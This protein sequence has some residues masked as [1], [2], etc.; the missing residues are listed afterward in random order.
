MIHTT[1]IHSAH[2]HGCGAA[3]SAWRSTDSTPC[4]LPAAPQRVARVSRRLQVIRPLPSPVTKQA[5]SARCHDS[6]ERARKCKEDLA[7]SDAI[8]AQAEGTRGNC[9][10]TRFTIKGRVCDDLRAAQLQLDIL[11]QRAH[12][13]ASLLILLLPRIEELT[14]ARHRGIEPRQAEAQAEARTFLVVR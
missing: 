4:S 5:Q 10:S 7:E 1:K 8:P 9:H 6:R 12:C 3:R 2:F 11:R 13:I 14:T